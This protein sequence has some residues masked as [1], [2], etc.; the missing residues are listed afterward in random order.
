ML[1]RLPYQ[2]LK[3]SFMAYLATVKAAFTKFSK[4]LTLIGI[5]FVVLVTISNVAYGIFGFT[6]LPIFKVS[7]DAFHAW[8][9]FI[10]HMFVFSW[11]TYS[12]EWL[13]YGL[14]WLC[15]WF[16]PII[17]WRPQII[18][19]GLL[20]DVALVSLAFTRVFQSA[21]LIVPRPTRA[22]AERKMTHE[23]WDQIQ[24]A[25]GPFWGP[26]HRFLDRTNAGIWNLIDWINRLL[27]YPIRD[28][29]KTST[30]VRRV[31]TSLAGSVLMW[32]FIRLAGYIINVLA[33]RHLSSPIMIV[34]RRFFKY[35]A[36]NLLGA[37]A[38][39]AIFFVLNG[40]LAD[41]TAPSLPNAP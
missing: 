32:G 36:L 34:R 31:L 35:F 28:F 10:L 33:A 37:I 38:A 19:P 25:E 23:L 16:V 5:F 41:Y 2:E 22:E 20:T 3:D 27:T 14:I 30:L 15:S 12:L 11:L 1:A 13:W 21:D 18:I 7:F 17:P 26:V 39:T 24:R 6:L 8:C 4:E 40:W 9:H 29:P